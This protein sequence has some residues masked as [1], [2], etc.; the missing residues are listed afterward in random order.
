MVWASRT[1]ALPRRRALDDH[2]V[3]RASYTAPSTPPGCRRWTSRRSRCGCR[4]CRRGSSASRGASLLV[5]QALMGVATVGSSAPPGGARARGGVRRRAD[6]GADPDHTVAIARHQQPGRAARALRRPPP[7]GQPI[8]ASRPAACAGCWR[9]ARLVGL[10]LRD[11]RWRGAAGGG[12]GIV[13]AWLW[14]APAGRVRALRDLAFGGAVMAVVGLRSSPS[15][16]AH[17]GVL[18]PVHVSGTDDN[19]IWSLILG[20]NGLGRLF[21]QSG[22]PGG[23]GGTTFDGSLGPARLLNEALG[24]QAS[25]LLGFAVVALVALAI[26]MASCSTTDER[27]RL[28]ARRRRRVPG[29]RG[30]LQPRVGHLCPSL[31]RGGAGAPHR[32]VRRRRMLAADA[33]SRLSARC[34]CSAARPPRRSWIATSATDLCVADRAGGGGVSVACARRARVRAGG[35]PA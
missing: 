7:S 22:G 34:C 10:W 35:P 32:A 13:A 19:S 20:S 16:V 1:P 3:A 31:L 21:G 30:H 8:A 11:R 17:A 27:T 28:A 33:R 18:A 26:V 9:R 6:A 29:H 2:L 23:G 12:P 14:V 25:W 15:D 4:R 5:P 24:G